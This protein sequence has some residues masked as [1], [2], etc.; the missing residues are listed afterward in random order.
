MELPLYIPGLSKESSELYEEYVNMFEEG[1]FSAETT[2]TG[3]KVMES[4]SQ[5]RRMSWHALV[6]STDMSKT[7][8]NLVNYSKASW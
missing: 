7:A 5:E 6:E 1:P 8:K 2:E 4:I 3:K